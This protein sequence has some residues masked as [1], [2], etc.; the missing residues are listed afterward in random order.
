MKEILSSVWQP[1]R[2]LL[3]N[4]ELVN[5]DYAHLLAYCGECSNSL[6]YLCRRVSGRDLGSDSCLVFWHHR[7]TETNHVDAKVHQLICHLRGFASVT[8]HHWGNWTLIMSSNLKASSFDSFT[9]L[10]RVGR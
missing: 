9:E 1:A 6:I 7:E 10:F 3:L 2:H 4:K 8:N 5:S